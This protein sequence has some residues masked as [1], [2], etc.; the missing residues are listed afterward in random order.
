M[1]TMTEGV[2]SN[3][4]VTCGYRVVGFDYD[5]VETV[6]ELSQNIEYARGVLVDPL[7]TESYDNMR[8]ERYWFNK[9]KT[10]K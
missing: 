2:M 1:F 7:Y 4:G 9:W 8:I 10:V 3:G 5:G 6:V